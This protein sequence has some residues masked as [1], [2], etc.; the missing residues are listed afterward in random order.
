MPEVTEVLSTPTAV[1]PF[2]FA[3][4]VTACA[5]TLLEELFLNFSE[6]DATRSVGDLART[7]GA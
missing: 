2:C 3:F 7:L 6:L 4:L 1:T 5:P